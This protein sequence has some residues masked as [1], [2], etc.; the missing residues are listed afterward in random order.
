[1]AKV[2]QLGDFANQ[3]HY[4]AMVLKVKIIII[5]NS[6]FLRS[7]SIQ[8]QVILKIVYKSVL[9]YDFY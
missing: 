9:S 7:K 2:T 8:N 1:M 4:K 6:G 3:N 5:T